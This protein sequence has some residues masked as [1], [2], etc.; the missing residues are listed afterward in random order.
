MAASE[1]NPSNFISTGPPPSIANSG[2][3]LQQ[4]P[5]RRNSSLPNPIPH[6]LERQRHSVTSKLMNSKALS[7]MQQASS[8]RNSSLIPNPIPHILERHRHSVTSQLMNSKEL[9]EMQQASSRRNSSLLSNPIPHILE[10]HRHSVTSKSTNSNELSKMQQA[11]SRRNS[12][13]PNPI[14]HI[15]ERHRHSVTSKSTNSNELSEM[16]QASSRRNSSLLSNPIPHILERHRHSVTSQ[17]MNSKELSEMQQASSRRNSSLLPN[18]IPH[19]LERHMHSVTSKELFGMQQTPSRRSSSIAN[20]F[21]HIL[22]RVMNGSAIGAEE[23]NTCTLS[24]S[25]IEHHKSIQHISELREEP[26]E[27]NVNHKLRFKRFAFQVKNK[28]IWEKRLQTAE[29][30][31]KT[32]MP[33]AIDQETQRLTF[34]L[35]AFNQKSYG[36]LSLIAKIILMQPSFNRTD[37]ELKYIHQFTSRLKCFDRYSIHVRKELA[38]VLYYESF[39]RRQVVIRQG[40]IGFNFYF[41]LSGNV[42]VEMQEEDK[43]TGEKQTMIIGEL[44]AGASFG[45]LALL[46]N[47]RRRATIVCNEDCE[48]LKID[49]PDYDEVLRKNHEWEWNTR[50]EYLKNHHLFCLWNPTYL[51]FAIQGSVLIE[52]PSDTLILKDLSSPPDKVFFIVKG[53]CIVAE[54]VYLLESIKNST[55]V[56]LITKE[57]LPQSPDSKPDCTHN[58]RHSGY[59]P[60]NSGDSR[61]VIRWWI[62]RTLRPG[63]YFGVGEGREGTSVISNMK[64]EILQV[65]KTVFK[66]YDRWK[67][68]VSMKNA[69][70]EF[71]PTRQAALKSYIQTIK[72][73]EYKRKLVIE[74]VQKKKTRS[75]NYRAYLNY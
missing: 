3:S 4:A 61:R 67:T 37:E 1:I 62:I 53:T 50:T 35:G 23:S 70:M 2:S 20:P 19:I 15:L 73:R 21:P 44:G 49:K 17:L 47:D 48:F 40:D 36:G 58:H 69:A 71:Y 31:L 8:R 25:K 60:I 43:K 27:E 34:N 26:S 66:N 72:W 22:E 9:S 57:K 29:K 10:R 11:S 54:K 56:H 16:Q 6:I 41:I 24:G 74:A 55:Q 18:P 59:R 30:N 52:Y 13:L 68:L 38:R 32:M 42:V 5:S 45:E 28:V 7:E 64:V 14:P 33:T 12:S 39:K 75:N 63:D 46:H 51:R 65:N